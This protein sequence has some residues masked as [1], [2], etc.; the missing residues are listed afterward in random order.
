MVT[1]DLTILLKE[2]GVKRAKINVVD[3]ARKDRESG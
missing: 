2:V 1:A 3:L